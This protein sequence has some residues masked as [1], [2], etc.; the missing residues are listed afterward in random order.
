M[1]EVPSFGKEQQ[2]EQAPQPKLLIMITRHTERLPSGVL[3]T[4]GVE[5]AKRKG[6]TAKESGAEV[7]KAYVSDHKSGRAFDTGDLISESS[8]ILSKQTKKHFR[9]HKVPDIQYD[10]LKPDLY[11]LIPEAK[12]KI[13]EATLKELGWSV[14]RDERGKLKI[15]IGKL[16]LEEQE[17]IA[18]VRQKNQKVGMQY[19][20]ENTSAVH[21]M[22]MGLAAQ[23]IHEINLVKSYISKR[24]KI[25]K[26]RVGNTVLNNVSHGLFLESLLKEAGVYVAESGEQ[27]DGISDFDNDDI[28]GY[29]EPGESLTLVIEDPSKIPDLIPVEFEAIKRALKGKVLIQWDKLESLAH[30]YEAWKSSANKSI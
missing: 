7:L 23:L 9:T 30:D 15:D 21:R 1:K 22:A 13:E 16:P 28:G 12:D 24:E 10:I 3:S 25:G 8:G 5:H 2:K 18:S 29:F 14:E 17:R 6:V 20:I 11:H 4:E 27:T 26:P 19:L